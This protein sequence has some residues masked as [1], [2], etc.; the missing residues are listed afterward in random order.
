MPFYLHIC[1]SN[2][3]EYFL[4]ISEQ[5]IDG[6]LPELKALISYH[7]QSPD[8][9]GPVI[10]ASYGIARKEVEEILNFSQQRE[11]ISNKSTGLFVQGK[12]DKKFRFAIYSAKQGVEDILSTLNTTIPKKSQFQTN[13][14]K[15]DMNHVLENKHKAFWLEHMPLLPRQQISPKKF[16][17]LELKEIDLLNKLNIINLILTE[18][19]HT[20]GNDNNAEDE[21][22]GEMLSHFKRGA[23][24]MQSDYEYIQSLKANAS[25]GD[26]EAK[27]ELFNTVQ[28][29]LDHLDVFTAELL[30]SI[31]KHSKLSNNPL[32]DN[33]DVLPSPSKPP[34]TGSRPKPP[35]F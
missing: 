11:D 31:A 15:L 33:L 2:K 9:T 14:I 6:S 25:S 26:S 19:F 7:N 12:P 27:Q 24:D 28:D 8:L 1:Q 13:S 20:V 35:F 21:L 22:A 29:Y 3:E 18:L 4:L 17:T 34:R 5:Q 32:L 30:E 16:S 10:V 23:E